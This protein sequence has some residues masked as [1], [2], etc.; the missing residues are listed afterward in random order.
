MTANAVRRY[1]VDLLVLTNH[2]EEA[3]R[4]ASDLLE[5][6]RKL[7]GEVHPETGR[8]WI[9]LGKS[10]FYNSN[11]VHAASAL[12][13]AATIF[14]HSLGQRHPDFVD[15]LVIRGAI[16]YHYGDYARALD[17]GR[18]AADVLERAYGPNHEATLKRRADLAS[19]L[20]QNGQMMGGERQRALF[21]EARDMLSEVLRTGERQGLPIAYARDEYAEAL[22]YDHQIDA[23]ERQAQRGIEEMSA[24]FDPDSDYLAAPWISM[25]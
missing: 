4:Q 6:N 21:L 9:V 15:A 5:S 13:R 22:L 12:D 17:I 3:L 11:S 7:F 25:L 16:A 19:L 24:L 14:D 18:E 20:L 1:L 2:R 8:A 23:A 10:W